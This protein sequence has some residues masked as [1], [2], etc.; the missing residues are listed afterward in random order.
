MGITCPKCG[1]HKAIVQNITADGS[2][3]VK[4]EDV[5]IKVLECGHTFGNEEFNEYAKKVKELDVEMSNTISKVKNA[6]DQQ[7]KAMYEGMTS[8]RDKGGR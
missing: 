6:R 3:A 7:V 1:T 4:A 8:K 2:P 5:L